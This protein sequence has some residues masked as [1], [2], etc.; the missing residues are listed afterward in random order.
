MQKTLTRTAKKEL[1]FHSIAGDLLAMFPPA[2]YKLWLLSGPLGAGKTTLI[3][4]LAKHL[5]VASHVTSPTF[6]L[7]VSHTTKHRWLLHHIDLYRIHKENELGPIGLFD[8]LLDE[9][10]ICAIEWPD[11]FM[12][13]F[14]GMPYLKISIAPRKNSR[15][16]V[17]KGITPVEQRLPSRRILP[18]HHQ[19]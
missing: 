16:V 12:H 19:Q 5:G 18:P 1:D 2:A 11:N 15:L 13:L 7:M 10:S 14:K 6:S 17:A 4:A 8:A 9:K 3:R